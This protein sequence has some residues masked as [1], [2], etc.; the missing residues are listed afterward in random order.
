MRETKKKTGRIFTAINI[1]LCVILI[2][3]ILLN[4]AV[5]ISSYRNPDEIPGIF[6]IKPVAVLS[7]SMEDTF[8]TG[9][10]IFVKKT[11]PFS[12]KENDVIC[13]L[14][15]GQAVTH[16]IVDVAQG[17][18]GKVSYTTMGDANNTEDPEPVRPE[19]VQGVWNGGRLNGVGYFVVFLS[20]TTGMI[21]FIVCPIV[22]LMIWDII[23]RW[24][25][26]Q[27]EKSR[28]AEL[29][30]E[31]NVLKAAQKIHRESQEEEKM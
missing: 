25:S 9:D 18:D 5:I 4:V 24:R 1:V 3:V 22:L 28:T 26:D 15:D 27:K 2:P 10:L 12:L 7:G 16:R 19:Q 6:G 31:L 21:V 29:E 23:R 14:L 20:S 11:D 17:E 8:L 30:A 13:F